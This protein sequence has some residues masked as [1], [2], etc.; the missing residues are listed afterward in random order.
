MA[1][2]S[3]V[4]E[5]KWKTEV[6][7]DGEGLGVLAA[8]RSRRHWCGEIPLP[9]CGL[10]RRLYG[11]LTLDR[12]GRCRAASSG[13]EAASTGVAAS[14]SGRRGVGVEDAGVPPSVAS[15]DAGVEDVR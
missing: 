4:V 15:P 2:A 5:G 1:S 10:T 13:A 9:S 11:L 3:M 12:L 7:A 14:S 6:E 8:M